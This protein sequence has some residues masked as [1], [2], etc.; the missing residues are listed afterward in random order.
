MESTEEDFED[1]EL[2]VNDVNN[3]SFSNKRRANEDLTQ[4]LPFKQSY[5]IANTADFIYGSNDSN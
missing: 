2:N 5:R 4:S 3:A 1:M